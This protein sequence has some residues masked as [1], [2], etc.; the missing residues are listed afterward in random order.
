M[1]F[2]TIVINKLKEV[3]LPF[4]L[5]IEDIQNLLTESSDLKNGEVSLPCFSL[6]KPLLQNPVNIAKK[7]S[8]VVYEANFEEFSDVMAING[9]VNF[10]FKKEY[11]IKTILEEIEH[12]K[13]NY[14]KRSIGKGKTVFIDFS[15][16]NLA[17]YMHIGHL[18]TTMMGWSLAK[19]FE[20]LGYKVI[21]INYVGDY[22]TPFGKMITAYKKWGNKQD[23]LDKGV[24]AIQDLYVKFNQEAVEHPE[25]EEEARAWFKKIEEKDPE[26]LELFN[27]FIDVGKDEVKRICNILG[28]EFDSWKGENYYSD[29]MQPVIEE[30]KNKN[31][32]KVSE[33][34]TVVDLSAYNLGLALIQ[35]SDGTSLYITRDL[36]AVQDRYNEFKFDM[37]FYVTGVEQKL[38]FSS[39]FKII[40]LLDKPYKNTLEHI[41]YGRYSLPS[42][43]ISSRFGKQ[44]IIADLLKVAKEQAMYILET[45]GSKHD[46]MEEIAQKIAVGALAFEVVKIERNKDSIFDIEKSIKF[47]GETS[48]YLQYSLARCNSIVNRVNEMTNYEKVYNSTFND[49]YF[50]LV[51]LL[52]K[53]PQVVLESANM[54]ET[55]LLT[56]LLMQICSEFNKFY[57]F[58][59]IIDNDFVNID[60]LNVVKAVQVVLTNGLR[61]LGIPIIEQM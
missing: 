51:K 10:Y 31:L 16:P 15:S 30:L 23:V 32:L 3:N 61:L 13:D 21:K 6:A 43:K 49:E 36:A 45:R 14:G 48:P 22:G 5:K 60:N 20:F 56:K 50:N 24:D 8:D 42:G 40:E 58:N 33:G 38:H 46:N 9:Y 26:A 39:L 7:I 18:K 1:N 2:K 52:N 47:E 27:W 37:G 41:H 11:V 53:F 28:V 19:I 17:K 55:Y 59:R 34:A 12:A 57:A 4:D 29:K 35:K 44:A 54:R 25:L